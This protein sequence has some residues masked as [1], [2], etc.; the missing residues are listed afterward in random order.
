MKDDEKEKE[1]IRVL[2]EIASRLRKHDKHLLETI[3]YI[4]RHSGFSRDHW[5][6]IKGLSLISGTHLEIED[7]SLIEGV[8]SLGMAYYSSLKA[9]LSNIDSRLDEFKGS[10]F[11]EILNRRA[12]DSYES[13]KFSDK[14]VN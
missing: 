11:D 13:I 3:E 7:V 1:D 14:K 6:K 2:E 9:L 5:E 10:P 8:L 12:V 4:F